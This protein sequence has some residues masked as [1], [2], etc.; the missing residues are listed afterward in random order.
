[1]ETKTE[2]S[3]NRAHE[4][5]HNGNEVLILRHVEKDGTS[6]KGTDR[7][8]NAIHFRYPLD[9]GAVVT[10]KD[11]IPDTQCGGGLHGW[12][13]GLSIGDGNDADWQATWLVMGAQPG[14][15]VNIGGKCKARSA[16]IRFVGRWEEATAFVLSG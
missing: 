3:L 6:Y 9:L 2:W 7:N 14:D 8:G 12:A 10:A 11:W 16:T 4:W 13:W 15:V 5:T 1:M